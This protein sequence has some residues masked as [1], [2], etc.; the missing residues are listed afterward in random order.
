MMP[1]QHRIIKAIAL[2]LACSIFQLYAQA[3]PAGAVAGAQ[4]TASQPAQTPGKLST[5]GNKDILV[6]QNKANT[7]AT[8]LD[9]ATLETS[10]CVSSTVRVG[11]SDEVVLA[12]NTV[13]VVNYSDNKVQV[14]L[15]QGCAIVRVPPNVEG[16]IETPD[17]KTVTAI[18]TDATGR[19]SAEVCYPAN[20]R[21]TF[22]PTCGVGPNPLIGLVGGI[23]GI[24]AAVIVATSQ[25]TNPSRST[26]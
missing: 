13:A 10:D 8:I 6:D 4:N 9:G 20:V 1:R 3:V 24:L 7:G 5:S 15:K 14:T 11:S 16:T 12:T 17:G 18:Q 26:P 22:T 25:G 23:A 21:R 19:K 2:L